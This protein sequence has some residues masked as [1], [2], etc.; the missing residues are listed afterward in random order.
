MRRRNKG[1]GNII[2]ATSLRGRFVMMEWRK[3]AIA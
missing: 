2:T 1:C 3:S